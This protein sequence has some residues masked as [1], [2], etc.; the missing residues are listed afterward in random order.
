MT[1]CTGDYDE[2]GVQVPHE[3]VAAPVAPSADAAALPECP[4]CHRRKEGNPLVDPDWAAL[5]AEMAEWRN[6][7]ARTMA[8]TLADIEAV[9]P[10]ESEG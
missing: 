3:P 7:G 6:Y 1:E 5:E 8:N 10:S 2:D 9:A 4:Y